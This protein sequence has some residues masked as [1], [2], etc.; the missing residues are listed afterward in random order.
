MNTLK[1]IE[2][3]TREI[4]MEFD[5]KGK[6]FIQYWIED[7]NKDYPKIDYDEIN[8]LL[9]ISFFKPYVKLSF[10]HNPIH[11]FFEVSYN[12]SY[13]N[14]LSTEEMNLMVL[15]QLKKIK[16]KFIRTIKQIKIVRL[17]KELEELK[18]NK[19]N[20]LENLRFTN[21]QIEKTEKKLKQLKV[22]K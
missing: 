13:N 1:K 16:D 22:K 10:N 15:E 8:D 11:H 5:Q 14:K 6:C 18:E 9:E 3:I 21:Q 17:K 20:L 19:K 7:Y 12:I 2:D 4:W